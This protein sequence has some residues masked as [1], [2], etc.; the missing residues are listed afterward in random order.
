[1]KWNRNLDEF[2]N[3]DGLIPLEPVDLDKINGFSDLLEAM[4]NTSFSGRQLGKA[5]RILCECFSDPEV[6]T[7]MTLSGA[8][9]VAKQ[10]WIVC[11][12]IERGC[13]DVLV[14]TGALL[15]HGLVEGM[16]VKHYRC[17]DFDDREFFKKGYNRIYDTIELESSFQELEAMLGENLETLVPAVD[18][19]TPPS[20]SADFCRRFGE[21]MGE[22]YPDDRNILTSAA[23]KDVPVYIPAFTD[24]EMGL[25]LA[26]RYIHTTRGN[27]RNP[28]EK[29]PELPYNPFVDLMDYSDRIAKHQG[30]LAIFTLGGGVPRNWAQQVA[31]LI[32]IMFQQGFPVK[33]RFF[34]R[35]V[36]ICPEPVHWGGL[37]GCTYKEGVSWGKF[38]PEQKGGRYAEVHADATT[39]FPLLIKAV[40]EKIEDDTAF[41]K[42]ER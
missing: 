34:S 19:E 26:V 22:Q 17:R 9:T 10:G 39:V 38:V 14:S 24:C 32:D 3:G 5:Y 20:G 40:F 29:G 41:S 6:M 7:V 37:S 30:S 8:L 2:E 18:G 16:G 4:E 28:F 1:M 31:P 15:T 11:D 21:L 27:A 13:V 23:K 33:Q 35:G 12:L 25:D 42:G 36:R